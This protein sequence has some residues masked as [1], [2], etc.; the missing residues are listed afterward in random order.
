[1]P[2]PFVTARGNRGGA[3][4]AA[5]AAP[6]VST[7][8]SFSNAYSLAFDGVDDFLTVADEASD[9]DDAGDISIS[10]WIKWAGSGAFKFIFTKCSSSS[11]TN[12][13][14]SLYTRNESSNCKVSFY[15]GG[16]QYNSSSTISSGAWHHICVTCDS[17]TTNGMK[18]YLDGALESGTGTMTI[19]AQTDRSHVFIGK[20]ENDT[21]YMNGNLDG[22]AIWRSV[23]SAAQVTNIY[24]GET[25]GGS[26]GSN[27][28]AGDLSTFSPTAW[29]RMGDSQSPTADTSSPSP[30]TNQG[31]ATDVTAAIS[32][33]LYKEDTAS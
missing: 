26:G 10:A 14:Y 7:G 17:G 18:M 16:V 29:W 20:R 22:V 1:M 8:D 3:F 28:T 9:L 6:A 5:P 11:H 30:V 33:A 23:L 25:N 31:S 27:G 2:L 12:R 15:G 13:Q 19:A 24:K 21:A 4:A 32:G